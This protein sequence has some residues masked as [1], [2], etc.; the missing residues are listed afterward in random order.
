MFS[1]DELIS[2]FRTGYIDDTFPS[3]KYY[4]PSLILNDH[5]RGQKVLEFL[6]GEFSTCKS[7]KLG[8]AFLTRSGVACIHQSLKD[9]IQRDVPG[10]ILISQYLNFSDPEALRILTRFENLE[11]RLLAEGNFHGKS[12][13]FDHEEYATLLI[14][15]SN[16]TQDALGKNTEINLSVTLTKQSEIYQS[17]S[18]SFDQW[19]S[20]ANAA[21]DWVLEQYAEQYKLNNEHI[22]ATKPKSNFLLVP[23]SMQIDA[24]KSLRTIRQKQVTR[25]LVI[26]ATGTG[27]TVLS[28]MD[29]KQAG[30]KRLL[31]VVHRLNIAKKAMVEF[32]KV[33][34]PDKSMGLYSG[35]ERST[36]SDFIFSTVQTINK[37]KHLRQ[38]LPDEFDYIIIDETHRA[39]AQTY[40]K[41]FNYFRPDFL[42]GMTATPERT[43][44]FDVFSLFDHE[45]GY[46]I[47]LHKAMEVNLLVPF[48]YFGITDITVDG[49]S[50]NEKS[51]FAKLISEARVENIIR[52]LNDYGSDNGVPRGLV[53]CSRVEEAEALA[54]AFNEKGLRS[55]ALSGSNPEYEREDSIRQLESDILSEKL[56]YIFTVDIFNEGIDIPKINQ[57][58]MLRPT[59]SAIIFVQQLGR[60]LRKNPGKEYLTV[61]DFIGNYENNYLIPVALFGDASYNKDRLRKLLSAGSSL[62]PG[63]STISF[64]RIA[65]ERIFASIDSANLQKKKALVEDYR[66]M[67]YRLGHPPMMMDFYV[68]EARDPYQFV[69]YSGSFLQFALTEEPNLTVD[70]DIAEL[71]SNLS[72]HVADGKRVYEVLLLKMLLN[73]NG[74]VFVRDLI[75]V[76]YTRTSIKMDKATLASTINSL[77][78]EFATDRQD[79]KTFSIAEIFG[80]EIVRREGDHILVGRSLKKLLRDPVTCLY[81]EDIY[82]YAIARFFKDFLR[83]DFVD[84]FKRGSKY[85]RKDV[86]R[87]L[88]WNQNQNAQNIGGYKV[89][90]GGQNCP[91]FVNYHKEETI[92][93]TTKYEDKF[94]NPSQFVYMSKSK[95]TTNSPDVIAIRNQ[96]ESEIRLPLFVKKSNDEGREFYYLGELTPI[97]E[98]F[99]DSQ[100]S[101][102]NG[103]SVSVVKMEFLLDKPVEPN[104]YKYIVTDATE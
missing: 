98:T 67:R 50:L 8:V 41:V 76:V 84:G 31:F 30:A 49:N 87:I 43:D 1:I 42:L 15:S 85:S 13:L 60:G 25:S 45:I 70:S 2:G 52:V 97:P 29:A 40:H 77:N 78:L 103:S 80:Y 94:I 12:Y 21:T 56:D 53:F 28:A 33:F 38:F 95:R 55:K 3:K 59:Q 57:I 18:T 92:S 5:K 27:K 35:T 19:F 16:L 66:L 90:P 81:L 102:E 10:Q 100:M 93:D 99:I 32:R 74:L 64:E 89:S 44:G 11:V 14:G 17:I 68:N 51:D 62:I 37:E 54:K 23:N 73:N 65:K 47:R 20:N 9:L 46:E 69:E 34:G 26:S 4:R 88:N 83:K 58:I 63:A 7:F 104:L 91:I 48:H 71:I 96:A 101:I 79:N 6:L 61:I 72:R 22:T 24:L 36:N 86:L 82:E 75:N 39:G